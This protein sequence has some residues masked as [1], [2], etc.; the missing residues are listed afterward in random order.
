MMQR[1]DL[2]P[3]SYVAR[4]RE[5]RAV[6]VVIMA[7]LL[8]WLVLFAWFFWLGLQISDARDDLAAV[9][10]RNQVL[11]QEI[12]ELQRFALLESEVRN[13]RRALA[14][15]MQGDV[16][17]PAVLTEVAMVIPGEV[18]LTQLQTSAA[19]TEGETQV[20]TETAPVDIRADSAFGRILFT[21]RSLSMPGVA[22]WMIR[23]GSVREFAAVWLTT[24]TRSEELT[25]VDVIDFTNTIELGTTAASGRFQQVQP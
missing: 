6:G 9:E 5:R 16:D 11:R 14:T 10:A 25:G 7:G 8:V 4:R 19:G 18:W 24:A 13:K 12:A 21:G 1:V 3:S 15:V 2:L 22:K 20:G 23:L 17:W